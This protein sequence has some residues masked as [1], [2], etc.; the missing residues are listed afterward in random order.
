MSNFLP[1]NL[2]EAVVFGLNLLNDQSKQELVK[3]GWVDP[4][5]RYCVDYIEII[6]NGLG[7]LGME[8]R[9]LLND[10]AVN[11]SDLLHFLEADGET[12]EPIAAIRVILSA[13]SKRISS[14]WV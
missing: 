10:I 2:E 7:I 12:V 14:D 11:H 3:I 9:Q 8:N 4:H 6:G 1:V 13:M 5:T